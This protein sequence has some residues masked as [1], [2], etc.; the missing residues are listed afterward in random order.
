VTGTDTDWYFISQS[1]LRLGRREIDKLLL[2]GVTV[3][4]LKIAGV[5]GNQIPDRLQS[6]FFLLHD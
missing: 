3:S 2:A 1:D 4:H 5:V 6:F